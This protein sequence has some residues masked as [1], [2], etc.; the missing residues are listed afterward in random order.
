MIRFS[1]KTLIWHSERALVFIAHNSAKFDSIAILAHLAETGRLTRHTTA[2]LGDM[3]ALLGA[4]RRG[5]HTSLRTPPAR[6]EDGARIMAPP[7]R[8]CLRRAGRRT[9]GGIRGGRGT[10][11]ALLAASVLV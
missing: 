9:A 6:S 2:L 3:L 1:E 10:T 7:R 5:P 11:G 4:P 8:G